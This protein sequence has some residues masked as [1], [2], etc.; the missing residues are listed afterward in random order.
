MPCEEGCRN[1][2]GVGCLAV[3]ARKELQLLLTNC[4]EMAQW[5]LAV[6]SFTPAFLP[7]E[8]HGQRSLVGCTLWTRTDSDMAE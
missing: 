8:V 3:G 6:I 1:P 5:E 2:Q 4:S 7:G